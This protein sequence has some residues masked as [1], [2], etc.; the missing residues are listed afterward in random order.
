MIKQNVI[1]ITKNASTKNIIIGDNIPITQAQRKYQIDNYESET[2]SNDDEREL[3]NKNT[4]EL[5]N[6]TLKIMEFSNC[7]LPKKRVIICQFSITM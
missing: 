5:L 1:E 4:E 6:H 2:D 3:G 7:P